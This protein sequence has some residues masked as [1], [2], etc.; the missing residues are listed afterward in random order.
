MRLSILIVNKIGN[1][2]NIIKLRKNPQNYAEDVLNVG[3]KIL[4]AVRSG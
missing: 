3:T 4:V 1:F 2:K